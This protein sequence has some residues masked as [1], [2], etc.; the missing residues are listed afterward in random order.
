MM[1]MLVVF[2]LWSV[3]AQI[4]VSDSTTCICSDD[5]PRIGDQFI[6][7]STSPVYISRYSG[8]VLPDSVLYH[9][10]NSAT[11]D[12]FY[13]STDEPE[14]DTLSPGMAANTWVYEG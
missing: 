3:E 2:Q 13:L 11:S 7:S 1:A 6:F 12:E 10:P 8:F 5:G 14:R 9:E 4:T